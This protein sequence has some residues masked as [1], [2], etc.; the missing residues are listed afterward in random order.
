VRPGIAGTGF[1]YTG[2]FYFGNTTSLLPAVV[3]RA[4]KVPDLASTAAV[5]LLR[6]RYAI[7]AGP[8]TGVNFAAALRLVAA[9][10][11]AK[12]REK[13]A[14]ATGVGGNVYFL[15]LLYF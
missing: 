3:D 13:T 15:I 2:P 14:A 4:L 1:G 5:H 6:Q 11:Q 7:D 8:S 10:N 9:R 12:K